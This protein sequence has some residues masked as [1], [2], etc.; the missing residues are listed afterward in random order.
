MH[1]TPIHVYP[2]QHYNVILV[3][4]TCISQ[5]TLQCYT[6]VLCMHIPV[7]ITMLYWCTMHAYPSQHYNVIL[8]YYASM[9]V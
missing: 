8:V 3:Y 1:S 9:H 4:Y 6:G 5:S 2:S 7:N